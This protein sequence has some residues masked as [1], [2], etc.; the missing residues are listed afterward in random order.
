MESMLRNTVFTGQ[1]RLLPGPT[2]RNCR[3]RDMRIVQLDV[4]LN[5][6]ITEH[7]SR[8]QGLLPACQIRH[9]CMHISTNKYMLIEK[10]VNIRM[11]KP[12]QPWSPVVL[13]GLTGRWCEELQ[14]APRQPDASATPRCSSRGRLR[15]K[16]QSLRSAH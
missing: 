8:R 16:T 1:A 11:S 7:A 4:L 14:R 15:L 5:K 13:S 6:H 10:T 9:A 2:R 12:M 3:P